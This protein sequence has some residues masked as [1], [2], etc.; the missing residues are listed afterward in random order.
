MRPIVEE[1]KQLEDG[2]EFEVNGKKET[3]YGTDT[4][5]VGDNLSSHLVGGFKAGFSKGFRKCRTCLGVPE[6]I[7]T[8][9][10]DCEFIIRTRRDHDAQCSALNV[11]GIRDHLSKLYG[12]KSN[13]IFNT[14]KYFHCIGGL[15][16][17]IM[18][19]LLEGVVPLVFLETIHFFIKKKKITLKYL[20]HI[21]ANFDY[22]HCESKDKPSQ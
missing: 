4:A 16:P 12:I 14:L 19:D 1:I 7:Q 3:F 2:V 13:S 8:K 11:Q 17:D 10:S 6:D 21:I 15:P 18:H 20:N 9:F 5:I 22:G